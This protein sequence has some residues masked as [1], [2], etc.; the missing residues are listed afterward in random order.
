M[1]DAEK[2]KMY[3]AQVGRIAEKHGWKSSR[4]G[5]FTPQE[6]REVVEKKEEKPNDNQGKDWWKVF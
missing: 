5:K 2:G 3:K 4:S 1:V 6:L